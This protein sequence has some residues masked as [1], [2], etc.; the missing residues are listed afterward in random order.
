MT[1]YPDHT[2]TY[3]HARTRTHVRAHARVRASARRAR[4]RGQPLGMPACAGIHT[5]FSDLPGMPAQQ[6]MPARTTRARACSTVDELMSK[7]PDEMA[8]WQN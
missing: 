1:P 3:V 5:T 2:R 6:G 7:L 4:T 8:I